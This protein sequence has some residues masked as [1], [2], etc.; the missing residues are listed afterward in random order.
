MFLEKLVG[1]AA[2]ERVLLYIFNYDEGY[3]A[4]IAQT[5]G[6]SH[7]QVQK[8]LDK[9]E[10]DGILVQQPKGRTRI[11]TWNPR[12]PLRRPLQDLLKEALFL[13]P[14]DIKAQY[15]HERRRPRRKGKRYE[16]VRHDD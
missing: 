12:W 15:F 9:F 1:S 5:F 13:L 14:E 6:L 8:Q 2:A 10:Q 11:Y 7:S 4:G 3:A 16:L